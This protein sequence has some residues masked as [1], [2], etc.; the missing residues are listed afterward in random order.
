LF[1]IY[2]R[3]SDK[4]GVSGGNRTSFKFS[5]SDGIED[6]GFFEACFLVDNLHIHALEVYRPVFLVVWGENQALDVLLFPSKSFL[7]DLRHQL[8]QEPL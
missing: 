7:A 4:T 3:T 5:G 2:D 1:E 6:K 8:A